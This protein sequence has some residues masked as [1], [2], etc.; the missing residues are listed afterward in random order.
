MRKFILS[1]V[2]ATIILLSIQGVVLASAANN[3]HKN[4]AH[5]MILDKSVQQGLDKCDN[6][7]KIN[8]KEGIFECEKSKR[9]LLS[10]YLDEEESSEKSWIII[11][12][13]IMILIFLGIASI[14]AD[15]LV[16][17]IALVCKNKKNTE[18]CSAKA[19]GSN[20]KGIIYSMVKEPGWIILISALIL[21]LFLFTA[22]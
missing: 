15:M 21:Y 17:I 19:L 8:L 7:F 13:L 4:N 5:A 12:Y 3:N 16:K 11:E 18:C 2:G 9:T 6:I 22:I 14:V 20:K 10:I 1:F